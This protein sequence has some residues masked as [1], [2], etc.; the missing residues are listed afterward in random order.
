[1]N[2]VLIS[3]P[4]GATSILMVSRN[5]AEQAAIMLRQDTIGV[6]SQGFFTEEKRV[7]WFK[8]ETVK[9]QKLINTLNLKEGDNFSEK[10]T[11]VKLVIKESTT[12][13]YNGQ[14][15]KVNPKSGDIITSNGV[16]V[17]R[18]TF[19]MPLAST[20]T[21]VRITGD[22]T[23]VVVSQEAPVSFEEANS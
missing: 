23:S 10:V 5:N 20:D 14:N 12:Q 17:Y 11:P 18:Q 13:F 9:L 8:G 2:K 4:E 15:P 6:N 7:A 22:T 3:K 21:D 16:P 1:M 19:V